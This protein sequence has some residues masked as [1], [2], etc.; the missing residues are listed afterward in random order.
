MDVFCPTES[1]LAMISGKWKVQLLR[2]FEYHPWIRPIDMA[3]L[4][5]GISKQVLQQNLRELCND[6]LVIKRRTKNMP[7][8]TE[9]HLTEQGASIV[10]AIHML[11]RKN[12]DFHLLYGDVGIDDDTPETLVYIVSKRWNIR[13]LKCLS[14][15][16]TPK[17]FGEICDYI[18]DAS[19]K[20]ITQQLRELTGCGMITRTQ[21][22]E[23]P[24]RVEYQLTPYGLG[25]VK[26]MMELRRYGYCFA[27]FDMKKCE[28][29][30]HFRLYYSN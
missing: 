20:V 16:E 13:I 1:I 4:I 29:C 26:A 2:C 7:P 30:G 9:Y 25:V 14:Q 23:M 12:R 5:P 22:P 19:A 3:E 21:Y 6:G 17:R 24:P 15:N 28:Q 18:P 8:V 10:D 11:H 27:S